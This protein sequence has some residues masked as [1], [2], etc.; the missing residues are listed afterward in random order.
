MNFTQAQWIALLPILLTGATSIAVMGAIA[1]KRHHWWN[2]TIS[3]IGLNLALFST[4]FAAH[5]GAQI[6]TPLLVVDSY[7]AFYMALIL[8]T[9]L[10][11]ATLLHAYMEGYQGEKEE[12][13]L[14]LSIAALGGVVLA[15][16]NHLAS[17]FIG[18]ELL[19]IPLYAMVAYPVK[20]RH[21]LEGGLKYLVL[22]AVASAFLLF[23]MAL[24][25]SQTGTLAFRG[26][27]GWISAVGA[28]NLIFATGAAMILAGAGFKLSMV[29][30]HLWTPDVYEGAPA[31]VTGFLATASKTAIFAV[32]LRLFV[33][34]GL[35]RYVGLLDVLTAI[36]VASILV[37]N[38]LALFQGNIKRMLAYSSIAHFGYLLV[39]LIAGGA[40]A[41][42]AAG[43]YL[44]TYVVTT[45]SAFGVVTLMSSPFSERDA[46]QIYDYR[47]LFWRRPILTSI[48]T[49]AMLSLAG[50]PL[51][52]G[53]IGK[54]YI[55]VA[56]VDQHLWILLAAVVA[57]S[58]IGLYYY[59][60]VMITLFL[61]DP[62]RRRF[63][64]PLQWAQQ[65]GGVI[66]LG[67]MLLMLLLGIY[68]GPFIGVIQAAG[69]Q[70]H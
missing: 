67:L 28:D 49:V 62:Q 10:A 24:I 44:I 58:A 60:R 45:L 23:G 47:G 46:T 27:Y 50:I 59:L 52:A 16:A 48:L 31:P 9:T 36:A 53:F 55:I 25:Y 66:M 15:C 17:F 38:V 43:V 39:A 3:V 51:T 68:P 69:L 21:A 13:Y 35:Y 14:L 63:S 20:L 70:I 26:I 18:V 54:F 65:A 61:L 12:I 8:V 41:V 2:A 32:L 11:T 33:E 64:A 1:I 29:P 22:S 37:G 40:L 5:S 30:F 7:A 56:G 57:G 4:I 34:G 42:E 6:V 19:S